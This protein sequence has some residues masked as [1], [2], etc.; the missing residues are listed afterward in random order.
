[1]AKGRILSFK[2]AFEGLWTAFREEPNLKIHVLFMV[3]VVFLGLIFNL[4]TW[5]WIVVIFAIG[6]VITMELT[7]TAIETI[8]DAFVAEHHPSAKRAKDI[9]SGAVLIT[10]LTAAIIGFIIF[11]PYFKTFLNF[12]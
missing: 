7:N 12:N 6:L 8:V 11:L 1:M 2:Y 5:Q 9:A 4:P 10:A 3:L